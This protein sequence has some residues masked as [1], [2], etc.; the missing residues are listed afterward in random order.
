MLISILQSQDSPPQQEIIQSKMPV[1]SRQRNLDL[2]MEDSETMKNVLWVLDF[3][4]VEIKI[5]TLQSN[6]CTKKEKIYISG[7]QIQEFPG[8]ESP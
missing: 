3:R 1:M 8:Y 5:S 7:K 6:T 4:I 2:K